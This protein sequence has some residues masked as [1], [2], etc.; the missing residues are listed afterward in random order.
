MGMLACCSAVINLCTTKNDRVEYEAKKFAVFTYNLCHVMRKSA[1]C[2]CK[3]IGTDQPH[4]NRAADQHLCFRYKYS[5][6]PH[7]PK[8]KFQASSHL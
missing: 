4:G 6:I 8:S 1:F 2:I 5:T 7:L 3:H